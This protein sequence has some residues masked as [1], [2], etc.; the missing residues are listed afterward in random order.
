MQKQICFQN[1]W[2]S[3]MN[4][5]LS[6]NITGHLSAEWPGQ[7]IASCFS[8]SPGKNQSRKKGVISIQR[9]RRHSQYG[10]KAEGWEW[11]V[12]WY[13]SQEVEKWILVTFSCLFSLEYQSKE[14]DCLNLE[15]LSETCRDCV[16]DDFRS[17]QLDNHWELSGDSVCFDSVFQVCCWLVPNTRTFFVVII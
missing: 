4:Y 1:S 7:C 11:P 15:S 16:L 12:T 13:H 10:K 2:F 9:S 17:C 14:W 8:C 6:R 5:F 3:V